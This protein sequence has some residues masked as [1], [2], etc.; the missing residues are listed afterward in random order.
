MFRF[1]ADLHGYGLRL[2][3]PG[4]MIDVTHLQLALAYIFI[5]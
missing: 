2:P 1:Y 3:L 5:T 4:V